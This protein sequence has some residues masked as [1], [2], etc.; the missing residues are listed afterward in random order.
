[1]VNIKDNSYWLTKLQN[2]AFPGSDPKYFL[3][4]EKYINALTL[5][6][7]QD[8]ANLLLNGSNVITAIFRPEKK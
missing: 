7:M 1:K 2:I 8:A 6:S 5:K 3:N 4:Y